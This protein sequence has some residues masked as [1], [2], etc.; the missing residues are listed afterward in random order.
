MPADRRPSP[1]LRARVPSCP[2]L[3]AR[4]STAEMPRA[5]HPAPPD[6]AGVEFHPLGSLKPARLRPTRRPAPSSARIAPSSVQ[7][8]H[9]TRALPAQLFPS[10]P[11]YL[12]PKFHQRAQEKRSLF[13][14]P[15][16]PELRVVGDSLS[17]YSFH[18]PSPA[19]YA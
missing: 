10:V 17:C 3:D 15:T 12:P 1:V 18:D 9:L 13:Y 14:A 4:A 7:W 8:A 11:L 19:I 16:R 5:S 6:A 2:G